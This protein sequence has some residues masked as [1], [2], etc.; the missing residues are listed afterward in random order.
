LCRDLPCGR[1]V[2]HRQAAEFH[3]VASFHRQ[4]V[5]TSEQMPNRL[6]QAKRLQPAKRLQR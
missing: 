3:E 1:G 6:M 5:D 2:C 4:W